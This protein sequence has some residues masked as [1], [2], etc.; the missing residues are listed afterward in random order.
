MLQANMSRSEVLEM[1]G[2]P[3]TWV[4]L[5]GDNSEFAPKEGTFGEV[6]LAEWDMP[7]SYRGLWC[8]KQAHRLE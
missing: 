4:F 8:R 6:D 7:A 5:P 2:T 3:P 1:L